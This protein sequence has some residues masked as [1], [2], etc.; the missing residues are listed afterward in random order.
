MSDEDI[1]NAEQELLRATDS[2]TLAKTKLEYYKR[3]KEARDFLKFSFIQDISPI[4]Y[5]EQ[6]FN[7]GG[8]KQII[9]LEPYK[10][11]R[12]YEY[13]Q[14]IPKKG[15]K[16]EKCKMDYDEPGS[17]PNGKYCFD[18]HMSDSS[19]YKTKTCQ[20]ELHKVGSCPNGKRC[21]FR[22]FDDIR[23]RYDSYK[24]GSCE[25]YGCKYIHN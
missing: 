25:I 8:V 18:I 7:D 12:E 17:C 4:S 14:I 22:H 15:R 9:S 3:L 10:R 20:Y 2:V 13:V 11:Q 1:F 5:Q 6:R 23:C 21:T 24:P 19:Y 16:T